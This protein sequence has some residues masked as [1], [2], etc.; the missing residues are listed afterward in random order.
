MKRKPPLTKQSD[1]ENQDNLFGAKQLG[2]GCT[3]MLA[4]L[5]V[6]LDLGWI[7]LHG[8]KLYDASKQFK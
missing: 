6:K 1:W 7:F 3:L 5:Q 4:V 2:I 8:S